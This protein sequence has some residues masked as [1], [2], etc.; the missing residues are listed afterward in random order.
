MNTINLETHLQ[1]YKNRRFLAVPLAGMIV[2]SL[3][4]FTGMTLS[5][6][7]QT[8]AIYIGTGSIVYLGLGLAKLTGEDVQF[9]K[10]A[11]R[12]PFDTIF[13]A[14]VAMTFLTFSISITFAMQNPYALPFAIAV[15]SG[16]MWLVHGAICKIKV[17]VAHAVVRTVL[18]TVAFIISPENSFVL[19]PSIVVLCYLFTIL[20]LEKRWA[21]LKVQKALKPQAA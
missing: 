15:Q 19:Q 2:W 12:N 3:R 1:N 5:L 10:G 18:C 7:M 11:E 4:I 16:L 14:A 21:N 17:C 20:V 13:L 9:K 8:W 6:H